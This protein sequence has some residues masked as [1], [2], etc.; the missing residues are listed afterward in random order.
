MWLINTT[1]LQLEFF[2]DL[3]NARPR[4]YAI[5]SHT[6][7][8]EEVSFQEF[9]T[10]G[11]V[12]FKKGFKKI[13]M[14]CR[15]ARKRGLDY[16]CVDTCC[17]DKTNNVELTEAINSMFLWYKESEVCFA[18]LSDL[19]PQSVMQSHHL[20][21]HLGRCRWFTRGWTLQ[22]LIAPQHVEILDLEWSVIGQ[23]TSLVAEISTLTGI[24]KDVLLDSNRLKNIAVARKMSWAANRITTRVEDNAYCLI[25]IFDINMSMIYGEGHKAFYRLQ[26]QIVRETNDLSLFAWSSKDSEGYQEY[27]GIFANSPL[28]FAD[29]G[30][31][32][33]MPPMDRFDQE[34][35]ITNKGL[36]GLTI[37]SM[38]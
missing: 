17:I 31:I 1:T 28:E 16:A 22:E 27:R 24:D 32:Q 21:E 9:Q 4:R 10:L 25:G 14:T 2:V 19:Q 30:S 37:N 33:L 11:S 7:A 3:Y 15:L 20:E 23:K 5:L 35:A 38:E 6:W 26:E 36:R 29:C 8:D 34:F 18:Y 13:E 12:S